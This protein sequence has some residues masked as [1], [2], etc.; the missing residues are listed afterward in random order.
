MNF[1]LRQLGTDALNEAHATFLRLVRDG[2]ARQDVRQNKF[3][4]MAMQIDVQSEEAVIKHLRLY[5]EKTKQDIRVV[6]EEHG[7]FVIGKDPTLT[8][9]IDGFDGS[10]AFRDSE[11]TARGGTMFALYR[12][13]DPRFQDYLMGG[14]VDHILGKSVVAVKGA[15]TLL[16]VGDKQSEAHVSS[17]K[18]LDTSAQI[19]ID[20]GVV[21]YPGFPAHGKGYF[22]DPIKKS[23]KTRYLGS[24]SVYFF[25]LV[26]GET[27][28]V[29][30]YGRKENLEHMV[31][32]PLIMESGGVMEFVAGG[33]LGPTRYSEYCAMDG[34]YPAIIAVATPGLAQAIRAYR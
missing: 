16:V 24:S 26:V 33:D 9:F 23:F 12:G 4:E 7:D 18:V 2:S 6:S 5:S 15:G 8:A 32:Y 29:L 27:D 3:G 10:S 13:S 25:D 22:F 34:G 21:N 1:D 31:A 28:V 30:E 17:G 19:D 14:I 11:G 20:E